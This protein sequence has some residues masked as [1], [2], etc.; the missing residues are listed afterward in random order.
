MLFD[1]IGLYKATFL[2][3]HPLKPRPLFLSAA[4]VPAPPI[5]IPTIATDA[6]MT[7]SS[8]ACRCSILAMT[9]IETVLT[10]HIQLTLPIDHFVPS[11][12]PSVPLPV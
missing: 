7:V 10:E 1:L 9:S 4:S 3:H 12:T 6:S 2:N 8:S 5:A 11:I